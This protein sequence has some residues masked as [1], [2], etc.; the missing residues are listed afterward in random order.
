MDIFYE[1]A[2]TLNPEFSTIIHDLLGHGLETAQ[3]RMQEEKSGRKWL[4]HRLGTGAF[5]SDHLRRTG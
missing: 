2:G 3:I 1:D 5:P 4:T